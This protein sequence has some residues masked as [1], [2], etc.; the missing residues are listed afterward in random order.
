[1]LR[2]RS[3]PLS[4][5]FEGPILL[6]PPPN[7]LGVLFVANPDEIIADLG[8]AAAYQRL[9]VP[10]DFSCIPIVALKVYSTRGI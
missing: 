3:G 9:D 4:S 10:F 7:Q 6:V 5:P 1:M 8:I 2:D